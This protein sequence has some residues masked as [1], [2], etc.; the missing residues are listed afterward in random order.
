[1]LTS[2][3]RRA[4]WLL[5]CW[6]FTAV[7]FSGIACA[8][9][10]PCPPAP[11]APA[12][13]AA[14][15]PRAPLPAPVAASAA[16]PEDD[17]R[18][19]LAVLPVLDDALF[20]DERAVLR[21]TLANV[22]AQRAPDHA[23]VPLDEVDAELRPVSATTGA[24]CAFDEVPLERRAEDAGWRWTEILRVGGL[25]GSSGEQLWVE[26]VGGGNTAMVTFGGALD[27]TAAPL[28]RYLKAFAA[29]ERK[30]DGGALLGGLAGGGGAG[31]VTEGAVT[32]CEQV[33]FSACRPETSSWRDRAAA[34]AACYAGE[35]AAADA[36]LIDAPAARCEIADLD[37][38]EG[39]RGKREACLCA[40]VR[41]S[42][43][44]QAAGGRR[45]LRVDYAAPEIAGRPRPELR[46][47][48]ATTNLHAAEEW[49]ATRSADV[50]R[51]SRSVHRLGIDNL[52]ALAPALARCEAAPGGLVV[53]QLDAREDGSV[54]RAR[55][56][57]G[58]P[59]PALAACVEKA[60]SRGRLACTR[61]G[62]PAAVRVA[63]EWPAAAR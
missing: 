14:P 50:S 6:I 33:P 38:V 53:A 20:R 8:V 10:R 7:S 49:H 63:V 43:G 2:G 35:D 52:D 25:P 29:L 27:P 62:K 18:P 3:S 56:L 12:R 39:P 51:V 37:D 34:L 36:L 1:M 23:L 57:S 46:V 24:R 17:E 45:V 22:L 26:L 30:P 42:A 5:H 60:L 21:Q 28:A 40:A 9:V 15:P 16:A 47:V 31:A 41:S 61:D 13:A 4:R 59:R 32:L 44:L 48:D 58:A 54:E 11:V 19:E 55:V